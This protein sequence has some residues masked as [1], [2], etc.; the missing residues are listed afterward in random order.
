MH[1]CPKGVPS[2]SFSSSSTPALSCPVFRYTI[3]MK[4]LVAHVTLALVLFAGVTDSVPAHVAK[5]Q[6]EKPPRD[7]HCSQLI[8]PPTS[9][10]GLP[11]FPTE[12]STDFPPFPTDFPTGFPTDFPPF[13]APPAGNREVPV[14]P[15]PLS[16]MKCLNRSLC[17]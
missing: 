13:P 6:G 16:G 1:E 9:R 3:I 2:A 8:S 17:L 7:Y 4:S 12:F 5:P 15:K 14:P 10:L 11:Q